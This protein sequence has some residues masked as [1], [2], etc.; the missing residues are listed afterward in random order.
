MFKVSIKINE[1]LFDKYADL[2]KEAA[3]AIAGIVAEEFEMLLHNA[4]Q[5][6]G[7]F[8]AN[9]AVQGGGR[10]GGKGGTPI[11]AFPEKIKPEQA[12]A[13]GQLPAIMYAKGKNPNIVKNLTKHITRSAGWL[14]G[15]TIYNKWHDAEIVES[16]PGA[17]LR[18]VN[19]EGAHAMQQAEARL[20]Q[21]AN[22]PI[23]YDS[24]EFHRLRNVK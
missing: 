17:E 21:R 13:R 4:P 24:A 2:R 7:N 23:L 12:M 9:M 19:Q 6:S 14:T 15:V 18:P 8:V 10:A 3:E 22:Q 1:K 5:Y 16:L 20:Q 11:S